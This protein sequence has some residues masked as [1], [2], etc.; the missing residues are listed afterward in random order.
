MTS[1]DCCRQPISE[2]DRAYVQ[3]NWQGRLDG[4]CVACALTRCDAPTLED[5]TATVSGCVSR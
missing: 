1:C 3:E 2:R 4:Y 5:D